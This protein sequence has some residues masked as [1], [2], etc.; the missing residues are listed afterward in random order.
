MN[1]FRYK[2][3]F[4]LILLII[5]VF[6]GLAFALGILFRNHYLQ[7]FHEQ[8][9]HGGKTLAQQIEE[10]GGISTLDE[11][12][13]DQLQDVL[14]ARVTIVTP[15]GD[16]L[17]D[18]YN[19]QISYEKHGEIIDK[20]VSNINIEKSGFMHINGESEFIYYWH[21]ITYNGTYE[22]IC[23]LL[24][25]VEELQTVNKNMQM[26]L[27][28]IFGAAFIIIVFIGTKITTKFTRP[29]ES[30]TKTA[31]ELAKGNYHAR[32][33]ENEYNELSMLSAS[34]NILA[35][36]LQ[37]MTREQEMQTERLM[38]VIENMGA[39]LILIDDQGYITLMNQVYKEVFQVEEYNI[40]GH[41]YRDVIE[42][43]EVKEIIEEVFMTEQKI[44]KM[45][46]VPINIQ[47]K[48]FEI[49]GAPIIG[50]HNE[51][52]GIVIVFHDITE[53]K[54]LEKIRKD[55]VA[56]VSHELKTPITS[57][58]G[59]TETLLE[60]ALNDKKALQSFLEII[61]KESN[62]LQSLVND[63]L[64]LSK[65]EQDDFTLS[66]EKFNLNKVIHEIVD[67]LKGRAEEKQI[68]LS[69]REEHPVT[70]EADLLRIQQIFINLIT[71]AISY[72]PVSGTVDIKISDRGDAVYVSVIDTGIGIEEK[73]IPRIF[74]RF[75]RVD[76]AR[77]RDSGGTGLGLAIV[78]HAVEAHDGE[79]QVESKEGK[80]STFTVKLWKNFSGRPD[81]R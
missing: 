34:I 54:K 24:D 8:L 39:P 51:W 30:A 21:P 49:F 57:I 14:N 53:L 67:S 78:K 37:Q 32:T 80:G 1:K 72:T 61:L 2:L 75:Y 4:P 55:F 3:L 35:R 40:I 60:G 71:N 79:I 16:V 45:I 31:I 50:S 58:K 81:R 62:R 10:Q 13:L 17:Y 65:I 64:E 63:L 77:S 76:K 68:S 27:T 25:K 70:I 66:L 73:E 7:I 11:K 52:K 33:Y 43:E 23:I 29:L 18:I 6:I 74:E 12:Q 26:L 19:K 5:I 47:L 41:S 38:T 15:E 44:R 46:T 36:N 56:N 28:S 48:T 59:F 9:E 20:I 22:G 42:N 69:I